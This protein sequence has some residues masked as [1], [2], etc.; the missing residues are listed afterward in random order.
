MRVDDRGHGA[1]HP[2]ADLLAR[3]P[4]VVGGRGAG[5]Q[6]GH[7]RLTQIRQTVEAER[8]DRADH[9]GVRCADRGRDVRRRG[10]E[11]RDRVLLHIAHDLLR[12]GRELVEASPHTVLEQGLGRRL[13]GRR[14]GPKGRS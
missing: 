2:F 14:R 11:H 4:Q 7:Q 3:A 1:L 8:L 9:R 10:G 5:L 13:G 6:A 12:R